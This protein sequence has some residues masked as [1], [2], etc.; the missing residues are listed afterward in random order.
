MNSSHELIDNNNQATV[1][2]KTFK[3]EEKECYPTGLLNPKATSGPKA[4]PIDVPPKRLVPGRGGSFVGR[5]SLC[6]SSNTSQQGCQQNRLAA[7]Y[8]ARTDY[9]PGQS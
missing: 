2:E 1:K 6:H 5:W 9:V 4:N 8:W 7:I 3:V